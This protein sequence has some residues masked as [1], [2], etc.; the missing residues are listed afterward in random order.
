MLIPVFCSI[1]VLICFN[2]FLFFFCN[3]L[4]V[5]L[6]GIAAV[7]LSALLIYLYNRQ[8]A[9][10]PE[11]TEKVARARITTPVL[12]PSINSIN[13]ETELK[14]YAAVKKYKEIIALFNFF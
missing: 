7:F 1:V 10:V 9:A 8:P 14:K 3:Q 11:S 6:P 12:Q 5:F 2:F 13:M 4:P